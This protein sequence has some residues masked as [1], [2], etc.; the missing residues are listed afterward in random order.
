MNIGLLLL[1]LAVGL[2][3]AAHGAQKLFGWFGGPGL[4]GTGQFFEMIGFRTGRPHAAMAGLAEAV[5]GLLL[6]LGLLTPLRS[7]AVITVMIVAIFSVH[8]D[9][10]FFGQSEG[11]EYNL[12]L[13][14]AGL[15][16]ALTG[17]GSLSLD[18][19]LG[20]SPSGLSA[21]LAALFVAIL[22]SV[23]LLA[24]RRTAPGNVK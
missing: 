5:G 6:T 16:I 24:Q 14:I 4:H 13:A 2:T 17:P 19:L 8:I 3:I 21:G 10:G 18:A 9:K 12:L 15:P 20:N 7:A 11:Y 1:R 22:A 23:V